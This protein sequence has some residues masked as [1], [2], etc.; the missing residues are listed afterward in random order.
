MADKLSIS[1]NAGAVI[2]DIDRLMNRDLP[3][4]S[5]VALTQTGRKIR[6]AERTE[7]Q[8]AFDRPTRYTINSVYLQPATPAKPEAVVGLKADTSKGTPAV[9]YLAPEVSGGVRGWKR[10][11]KALQ[12]IGAMLPDEYAIPAAG[13]KLDAYGNMS[14]AKIVQILSYL[15]A[16]G[17]Q[18]YRANATDKSRK[19]RERVG[20]SANG[21]KTING[22]AYFVARRGHRIGARSWMHGR[23]QSLP[24]GVYAKRGIHGSDIVPVLVFVRAPG[25]QPRFRFFEVAD[26]IARTA[27]EGELTRALAKYSRAFR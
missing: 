18:G 16:F 3:F 17:E 4:A 15:R 27:F 7:I 13:A 25:Y 19:R 6:D 2:R 12:R 14:R 5:V 22:V 10:F 1:G 26:Q 24:S 8:R 23:M 21:F 9:K 20:R 11:E